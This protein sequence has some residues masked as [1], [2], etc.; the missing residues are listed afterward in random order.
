MNFNEMTN[1]DIM[2]EVKTMEQE[3]EAIK[4]RILA[5][6]TKMEEIEKSYKEAQDI[7]IKRLKR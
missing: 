7:I 5:E 1:N 4:S 6:V 3:H 2:L